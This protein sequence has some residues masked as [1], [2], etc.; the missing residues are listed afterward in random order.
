MM[1]SIGIFTAGALKGGQ[2]LALRVLSLLVI[3]WRRGRFLGLFS[4]G[5]ARAAT[6]YQ[7]VRKRIPAQAIRA[8]KATGRFASGKKSGHR[9]SSSFCIHP[10]AAH[11]VMTRR[12]DFHRSLGDV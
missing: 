8:V 3:N 6:E 1:D 7:Q 5:Q 12:T 2:G 11:H 10:N 4:S 9:G